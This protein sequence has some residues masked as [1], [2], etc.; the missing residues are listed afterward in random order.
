MNWKSMNSFKFLL[1]KKVDGKTFSYTD[2][3]SITDESKSWYITKIMKRTFDSKNLEV[4]RISKDVSGLGRRFKQVYSETKGWV[5]GDLTKVNPILR[6]R[7]FMIQTSKLTSEEKL[8]ISKDYLIDGI[9]NDMG[10]D[11]NELVFDDEIIRF[12]IK[13]YSQEEGVRNLKRA[14]QTIIGKLNIIR[15]TKQG[16]LENLDLP[17]QLDNFELPMK[18][19][20]DIVKKLVESDKLDSMDPPEFMYT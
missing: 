7:M 10:V 12:I 16:S 14:F 4:V 2:H 13:N 8:T 1:R 18:I 6:D 11:K 5:E 20:E 15:I 9:F 17:F 3:L 19:T